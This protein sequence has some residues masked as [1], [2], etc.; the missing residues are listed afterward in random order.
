VAAH[1][2]V[3]TTRAQAHAAAVLSQRQE[4]R[5]AYAKFATDIVELDVKEIVLADWLTEYFSGQDKSRVSPQWVQQTSDQYINDMD[6]F[7]QQV[8]IVSLVS[9]PA[10]DTEAMKI[11]EKQLKLAGLVQ[12][13]VLAARA[14]E[15]ES[16]RARLA[17]LNADI[18]DVE[19]ELKVFKK[20]AKADLDSLGYGDSN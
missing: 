19:S 16:T 4:R 10:V 2:A 5:D 11:R 7:D 12:V 1:T 14:N 13:F 6:A 18:A 17:E 8:D 3:Y 9:S 15:V 20:A